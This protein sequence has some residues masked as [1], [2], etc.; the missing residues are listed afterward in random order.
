[1]DLVATVN[2]LV[3]RLKSPHEVLQAIRALPGLEDIN[4][5]TFRFNEYELNA[6][7]ARQHEDLVNKLRWL[8]TLDIAAAPEVVALI[9]I[10]TTD[11]GAQSVLITRYR[12]CA[13]EKLVKADSTQGP[14]NTE[15]VNRFIEDMRKLAEHGALNPFASRGFSHWLVC[16]RTGTLV[17]S[18]W[19][20]LT[21]CTPRQG[22]RMLE[23]LFELLTARQPNIEPINVNVNII[24]D[25]FGVWRVLFPVIRPIGRDEALQSVQTARDAGVK[26]VFLTDEGMPANE[27]LD[28]V[29]ES[30]RRF[31]ELWMGVKLVSA[32]SPANALRRALDAC[33]GRIDGIWADQ[34]GIDIEATAKELN[35][36]RRER[37]WTGLYFGGAAAPFVDVVCTSGD[38][39]QL[40]AMREAV[41]PEVA[42]A[43]ASGVTETNVS[44]YLPYADAFLVSTGIEAKPGV[45]DAAKLTRL[46]KLIASSEGNYGS[47]SYLSPG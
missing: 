2:E 11:L 3:A 44:S 36:A 45:L 16:D 25:I 5:I 32:G 6:G 23:E 28:L 29:M 38:V 4:G 34:P 20:A 26:G 1:M 31:P 21:T 30:R 33:D 40:R 18:G 12:H 35:A 43:L 9:S 8:A 19:R 22:A 17:L 27:V 39:D 42:L 37:K 14:F 15:A 41:G 10:G 7:L 47:L 46:Q 13:G 24:Q